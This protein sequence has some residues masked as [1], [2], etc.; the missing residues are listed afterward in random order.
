[1][2]LAESCTRTARH[3]QALRWLTRGIHELGVGDA[4]SGDPE[5]DALAG[6]L[7][8][9]YAN[10]RLQLGQP[11]ETMSW[12]ARAISLAEHAGSRRGVAGG[13]QL[14]AMA[15]LAG[16]DFESDAD[17]LAA[18]AIWQELDN[19]LGQAMTL[20]NLGARSYYLGGWNEALRFYEQARALHERGGNLLDGAMCSENMAEILADQGHL[21]EAEAMT[22]QA[23]RVFVGSA[24]PSFVAA[25]NAQLGLIAMRAGRHDEARGLLES[26]RRQFEQAGEPGG[27]VQ[28]DC[29]RAELLLCTG[30]PAE[31]VALVEATLPSAGP[32]T[33]G[34]PYL[35][36]LHRIQGLA[37]ADTDGAAAAAALERSLYVARALGAEHDIALSLDALLGTAPAAP[38]PERVAER[39][40]LWDK[41]GL[42]RA[43]SVAF[44]D[45]AYLY[46]RYQRDPT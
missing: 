18:L 27:V 16:G 36:A 1:M 39:D 32:G 43:R 3:R 42:A 46:R 33:A 37:L 14:R 19:T 23:L 31:A 9:Q 15:R 8:M 20:N 24:T 28:V 41:L 40:A 21:S 44:V 29:R 45:E 4:P 38:D 25:A 5:V 6:E 13:Y 35:P 10:V 12:A 30:S 34:L 11:A 22:R 17:G 7:C 26:A 2:L